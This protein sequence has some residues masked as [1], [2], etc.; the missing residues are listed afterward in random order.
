MTRP[1]RI[2]SHCATDNIFTNDID[3]NT[4]SGL[5]INDHLP[6]FTVYDINLRKKLDK[7]TEY[8][9][10]RSEES[11]NTLKELLEQNWD[12]IYREKDVDRVYEEFLR[13][14]TSLY[15]KNCPI[16]KY[17]RKL[18]NTSCPWI[19]KG[20]QNACKKKNTLYRDFIRQRTKE[21]EHKYK[22]Y[23]NKLTN[24]LRAS[25]KDYLKR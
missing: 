12:I 18:S 8:R 15:D 20:I 4:I 6:V 22:K 19:T 14:F 10:V 11:I 25:K 5:L 7:Q 9:P 13:I 21:A 16:K 1:N 24:I 2:T 3:N 23:K 17:N